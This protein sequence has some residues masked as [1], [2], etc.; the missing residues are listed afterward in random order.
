VPKAKKS[1]RKA[2]SKATKRVPTQEAIQALASEFV[3]T[4]KSKKRPPLIGCLVV[5]AWQRPSQVHAQ[6]VLLATE[7]DVAEILLATVQEHRETVHTGDIPVG[8]A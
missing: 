3:R 2:A 6:S 7:D 4:L 8:H 5:V 1:A